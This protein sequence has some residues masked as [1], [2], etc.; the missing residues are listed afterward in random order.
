M[1]AAIDSTPGQVG[2][3][4]VLLVLVGVNIYLGCKYGLL[5]RVIALL[6]VYVACFAATNVGNSIASMFDAHS[7]TANAWAFV[8]I[9]AGMVVAV[10]MLGAL[11]HDR[12]QRVMVVVFDR[13]TGS[14][15]GVAVGVSEALVLFLV[16]VAVSTSPGTSVAPNGGP[17]ETPAHAVGNSMVAGQVVR[18]EPQLV[19]LFG[20]ALPSDLSSHLQ[21]GT[22]SAPP[23]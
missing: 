7:E 11:I 18:L 10:E 1:L 9:F 19:R 4:L 12:L 21:Q 23:A 2:A 14:V 15:L 16:V 3:D 13:I 17:N 20:P 8:A 6:G 5:R 22:V